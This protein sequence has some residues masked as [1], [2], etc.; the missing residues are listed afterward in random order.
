[1]SH[2]TLAFKIVGSAAIILH[3]GQLADPLNEWSKAMKRV[4][5]KRAKTEADFAE[6][7][8][9]EWYGGLYTTGGRPCLPGYVIEA[10]LVTAA[11][12]SKRGK[13]AQ[14][15]IFCADNYVLHGPHDSLTIDE[16]WESGDYRLTVGARVGNVRIMRTRPMFREWWCE[17]EVV[18]DDG[19]LN[20]ADIVEIVQ[21]CGDQIGLCD[22]RPKYGRFVVER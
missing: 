12:K 13:Q 20:E 2:K 19:M 8:K 1:M 9:I 21:T 10:A 17:F 11:K 6:M 18:F 4:S 3:S 5:S 14:A 15:G 22:W 16:M 7:A